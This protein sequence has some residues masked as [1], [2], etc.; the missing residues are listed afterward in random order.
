MFFH[1][2]KITINNSICLI[3]DAA[4]AM[5]EEIARKQSRI[6]SAIINSSSRKSQKDNA[7]SSIIVSYCPQ[8][9]SQRLITLAMA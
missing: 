8:W 9:Y 6:T 2:I 1:Q 5:D 4:Y 3:A 7:P